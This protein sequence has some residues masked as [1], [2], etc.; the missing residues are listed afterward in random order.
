M[1]LHNPGETFERIRD[2]PL[3]LRPD[4][5][6][7]DAV[8]DNDGLGGSDRAELLQPPDEPLQGH[9]IAASDDDSGI[10]QL[11]RR[12]RR[13]I[14]ARRLRV[15]AEFL[16]VLQ[17]EADVHDD[18]VDERAAYLKDPLQR[19]PADLGPAFGLGYPGEDP[20]TG[21]DLQRQPS[22]GGEVESALLGRSGRGRDAWGFVEQR[23]GL[24]DAPAIGVGVD[25]Q[26]LAPQQSELDGEVDG[27]RGAPWRAGR[28]PDRNHVAEGV[29]H[30]DRVDVGGGER[31][32]DRVRTGRLAERLWDPPAASLGVISTGSRLVAGPRGVQQRSH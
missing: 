15:V 2:E 20:Q 30:R 18:I 22:E 25:Q 12:E 21:T 13:L 11:Q 1:H 5:S 7:P 24:R 10:S 19:G 8:D 14:A 6:G 29:A 4:R 32:Q 27:D 23:E 31:R 26:H 3:R 16:V 17:A 28:A 9:R